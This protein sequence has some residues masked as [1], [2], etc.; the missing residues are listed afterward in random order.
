M[1]GAKKY[2]AIDL[3][4]FYASVECVE[5]GLD[6]LTTN[7]VVADGSRTEKTIC[8]A[9]SPSLKRYGIGGR[10]RLFEVVQRVK[11]V[12]TERR[13]GTQDGKLRGSSTDSRQ[14]DADP[15]LQVDYITA[16]PRM[17]FYMKYSQRIYDIYLKYVDAMDIFSYSID[18]VFIDMT[19]YLRQTGLTAH[20]MVMKMVRNVLAETGVTA[21]AGIGTNMY[22]AK[23]AMDIVAK[24]M[25]ADKDG[26]RVAELDEMEYR[27][28]LWRH[29]PLTD[30]WR[31]GKGLAHTLSM[32]GIDTMGKLARCSIQNEKFLYDLFGV[33]AELIIDHAWAWEP[34]TIG[35]VKEYRPEVHS[36]SRGQ[37]LQS[38][39][40]WTKGR[41]IAEEMAVGMSFSLMLRGL[42]ANQVD[43]V[44]SYDKESLENENIRRSYH[45]EVKYNYYGR[46]VPKPA[47]ASVG[48]GQYTSS[49]MV[50]VKAILHLYDSIVDRSLLIRRFN[51]TAGGVVYKADLKKGQHAVQL[52]LFDEEKDTAP[53]E[54]EQMLQQTQLNLKLQ[55][56][57]N[58]VLK[59]VNFREGATAKDR[60]RQ[61]GGHRE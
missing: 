25:P 29:R 42:V 26:V 50:I 14:L 23:V 21:T 61:I 12:N 39:Y 49:A 40:D 8:L 16:T 57:K 59:G 6:P 47:H 31:I 48:L 20:D 3:K 2:V 46:R 53:P 10:A 41:V 45:G 56:G 30:F 24:K 1:N 34:C 15:T 13:F 54:K 28:Q 18:E 44:V 36:L 11:E 27:R 38:A 17:A 9:V 58:A 22:L 60:N 33:N 7:L 55:F 32:H 51:V 52:N 37:V 4:S 35:D 5:R 43:L 19:E